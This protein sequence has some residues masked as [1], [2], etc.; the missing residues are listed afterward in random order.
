MSPSNLHPYDGRERS[1]RHDDGEPAR[2]DRGRALVARL[3]GLPELP[4]TAGLRYEL[5]Y[6]SGGIGAQ[7]HIHVALPASRDEVNAAVARLRLV[8]PEAA[9]ADVESGEDV[10]WVL[11]DD[12]DPRPLA[13]AAARFVEEER[14]DFQPR[15]EEG[16]RVWLALPFSPNFWTVVYEAGGDLCLIAFD[17]G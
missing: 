13:E 3:L 12:D 10:A 15:P 9:A 7:D 17:Q 4:V 8:T 11:L 14:A 16:S 5:R 6:Y 2:R 1:F